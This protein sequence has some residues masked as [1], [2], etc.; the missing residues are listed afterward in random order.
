M[1]HTP[2][3]LYTCNDRTGQVICVITFFWLLPFCA[4]RMLGCCKVSSPPTYTVRGAPHPRSCRLTGERHAPFVEAKAW[5]H[6]HMY[7]RRQWFAHQ[8]K[9]R[10]AWI[11]SSIRHMQCD[12]RFATGSSRIFSPHPFAS[13]VR[14]R[15]RS[16][17]SNIS[18]IWYSHTDCTATIAFGW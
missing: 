11:S 18:R 2:F 6:G 9:M 17:V 7:P 16:V 14:V 12:L 13:A 3:I 1:A 8:L 5:Q 4:V 15:L 10:D